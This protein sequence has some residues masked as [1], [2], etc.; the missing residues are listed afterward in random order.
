M[1]PLKSAFSRKVEHLKYL[2]IIEI[3]KF[4][5]VKMTNVDL[6]VGNRSKKIP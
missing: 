6:R 2:I 4:S 3:L 5:I 1:K